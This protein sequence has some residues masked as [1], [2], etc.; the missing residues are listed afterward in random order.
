MRGGRLV[1][2][3]VGQILGIRLRRQPEVFQYGNGCHLERLVAKW[4]H[5]AQEWALLPQGGSC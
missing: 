5:F 3:G 2:E 4:G 1:P